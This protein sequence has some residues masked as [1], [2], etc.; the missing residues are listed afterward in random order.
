MRRHRRPPGRR[1]R[2]V[3][4]ASPRRRPHRSAIQR[5][6]AGT[7]S[8]SGIGYGKEV[9]SDEATKRRSDEG[10]T[11]QS[12]P[13]RR[14][15]APSLSPMISIIIP[16]WNDACALQECLARIVPIAAA[17]EIIVADASTT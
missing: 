16:C 2:H 6:E 7:E 5:H 12:S 10:N 3:R 15:V 13:L 17:H 14:F 9:T 8:E 1:K 4:P 11:Y